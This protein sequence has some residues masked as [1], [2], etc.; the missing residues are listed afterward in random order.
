MLKFG[1]ETLHLREIVS[2][3]VPSNMASRRVMEKIGMARS[4]TDDF[5]HPGLPD[6]HPLK[7]HVLYRKSS[8]SA[9]SATS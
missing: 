5:A 1:F 4:P 6:G 3:T 2:F 7:R 8:A 9:T